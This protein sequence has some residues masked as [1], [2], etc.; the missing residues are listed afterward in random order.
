MPLLDLMSPK[1]GL[2]FFQTFA[3]LGFLFVMKRFVWVHILAF[4]KKQE[5]AYA[6]AE[7][8]SAKAKALAAD[9]QAASRGIVAKAERRRDEIIARAL[10]TKGAYLEEAKIEGDRKKDQLVA[11]GMGLLKKQ[12]VLA[13]QQIKDAVAGL[14]IQTTEKLLGVELDKRGAREAL[15]HRL[16]NETVKEQQDKSL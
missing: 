9:L 8:K 1:I 13:Q 6:F 5:Q 3:M 14:V 10:A 2:V 7:A 16:I 12:E 15:L 11:E 4:I